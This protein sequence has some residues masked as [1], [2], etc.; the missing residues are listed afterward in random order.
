MMSPPLPSVVDRWITG[1]IRAVARPERALT[2][3]GELVENAMTGTVK[4]RDKLDASANGPKDD[5]MNW[6]EI[7]WPGVDDDVRRLRQRIFTATRD[8]D[9]KRVRNL[10]K[11]MLR[12][13]ANARHSVRRVTQ[14]N[15][16]RHTAGVD[17]RVV[18]DD[19]GRA[20]LAH[21][22]QHC[23]RSYT[24]SPVR[25]V[26]IPKANGKQ[27]PLGIPVIVDR[28]LQARAANAL[29]PEWEARFEARSYGF[30]AGR[31]CHDAITAIFQTMKGPVPQRRWILDAD[32]AA[33]F[34]R[35]DHQH[36][37]TMIGLFPA[38]EQV[39]QWLTAGV[40]ERE[41]FTPT[42][43]GTPQGGVISPT[44]LNIA[45]HGT[46]KAAG[47]RYHPDHT[48]NAG[49]ALPGTP[50]VVKYA[51]DLL[52]MCVSREQA[53]TVQQQLSEWLA[54]RGLTFNESKTA[55]VGLDAGFDFLGFNIRRYSNGKLLIKPSK[56]A[57]KRVRLRL[58]AEVKAL[59]G[60]NAQAVIA[61]LNPI[62]RGWAAYYRTAVSKEIFSSL[63]AHVWQLTWRWA[64]RGHPNKPKRWV[65]ARY[66]GAFHSTRKDRWLFGDRDTGRYLAKFA[67]TPI[68]RHR[69]VKGAS[70]VDDPLLTG[71]WAE[72]R[73][74]T[75][76]PV[77]PQVLDM[78]HAQQWRCPGCGELLLHAD[79]P[80]QSPEQWEQ[81]HN[82][83]RKA[84]RRNAATVTAPGTTDDGTRR[85]IH[86]ACARRHPAALAHS[87]AP[88][89][90]T[91]A[92]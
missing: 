75:K 91:L 49:H 76:L 32:L 18:L 35:I 27:R 60:A 68:V 43:E 28:A 55:I 79:H 29:E 78:L 3:S 67:W 64:M 83:I 77:G 81:W 16:G 66:F 46:E 15:A 40:V 84:L 54:P 47:V 30:R 86:A 44:L 5:V 25:R 7:D 48:V 53:Q 23:G 2:R 42:L 9:L 74:R 85:L 4:P 62:I 72:R 37:L 61:R 73:R 12:S 1:R 38:R 17:G 8:G 41:Q 34:D 45:L 89:P 31:G 50:V 6:A 20:E 24:P 11:L 58:A 92:N 57:V 65:Q 70:S 52:V 33:A 82:V 63:D 19:P 10:Q 88:A 39:R 36:L 21:Q 90:P 14:I 59:H 69:M 26:Y 71:Y 87:P 22:I 13:R 56:A 80:P 51:D